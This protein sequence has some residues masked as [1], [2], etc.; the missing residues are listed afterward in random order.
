[1]NRSK[2]DPAD[3]HG[4]TEDALSPTEQ[5]EL[6]AILGGLTLRDPSAELDVKIAETL[7]AP[8]AA[9]ATIQDT[10]PL[11][12]IGWPKAVAIAA[13]IGVAAAVG[14][15]LLPTGPNGPVTAPAD[16]ASLE[17]PGDSPSPAT[18]TAVVPAAYRFDPEPINLTW[19]RDLDRGTLKT[20]SG[21][22]YRTYLREA[23]DQRV[24]T[25]PVN[26]ATMQVNTPRT[27]W[28]VEYQPTF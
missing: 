6:E 28:I 21:K 16:R 10:A 22:Q 15:A 27:E 11:A 18:L 4:P 3:H 1:M 8:A 25:D 5:R 23:V 12:R 20:E 26:Q 19:S 17:S 13:A 2:A 9:V 14:I 7:S 24:Y